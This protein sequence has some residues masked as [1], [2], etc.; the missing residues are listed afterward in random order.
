MV[1]LSPLKAYYSRPLRVKVETEY[2]RSSRGGAGSAKTG[3]LW[4]FLLP[5]IKAKEDGYDQII[6]LDAKER[7]FIEESGTMNIMFIL[8]GKT[9]LTPSLSDSILDGITRNSILN[10]APDLGLEVEERAIEVTEILKRIRSGEKVE[11]FGV[12]TAAVISP[13]KEIAYRDE[14]FETFVDENA[15]MYRI[16]IDLLTSEGA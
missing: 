15:D 13:I 9:L 14:V 5:Q 6:W 1:V 2:I 10:L 4:G 3:E 16:K 8:N 11:A 12:G 7:K